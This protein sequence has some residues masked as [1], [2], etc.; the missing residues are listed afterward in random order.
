MYN[1]FVTAAF[2]FGHSLIRDI[3]KSYDSKE[4]ELKPIYFF[5]MDFKSD[6]A[7]DAEGQGIDSLFRGVI[8]ERG[9]E[10]GSFGFDLQ[11]RLEG[12][13]ENNI[14]T[15]I[16]LLA[17]NILRGRDHG[18]QPYIKYVKYCHN[19]DIKR[20]DDLR[21]LMSSKS[22]DRLRSVYQ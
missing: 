18:L 9:W 11:N 7:Y 1:E 10:W 6:H 3:F 21:V 13:F 2:R 5:D 12:K 15:A 8:K 4:K 20:F 19:I 22:V 16:D 17:K 14:F